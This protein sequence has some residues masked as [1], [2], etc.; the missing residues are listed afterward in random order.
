MA[1][2]LDVCENSAKIRVQRGLRPPTSGHMLVW[3]SLGLMWM[4]ISISIPLRHRL[5]KNFHIKWPENYIFFENLLKYESNGFYGPPSE[6]N[7]PNTA[8]S[9]THTELPTHS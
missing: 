4:I 5:Y 7:S 3:S 6:L 9:H 8:E 1:E 2:N